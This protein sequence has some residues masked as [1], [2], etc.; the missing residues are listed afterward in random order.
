MSNPETVFARPWWHHLLIMTYVAAPFANIL[1]VRLFLDVPLSVILRRLGAGFG[2]PAT[3]WLFTAPLVGVSLY[4]VHGSAGTCS[5]RTA[6]S[7]WWI[8]S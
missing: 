4:L 7:S 6:A 8:S 1:L 2:I 5:S 3:I